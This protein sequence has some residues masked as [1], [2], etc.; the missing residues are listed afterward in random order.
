[1]DAVRAVAPPERVIDVKVPEPGKRA[2]KLG[3]RSL[4]E[5]ER[6]LGSP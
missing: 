4:P 6:L 2:A 5:L 3:D 1:V